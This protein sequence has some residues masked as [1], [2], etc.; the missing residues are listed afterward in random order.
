M[1]RRAAACAAAI[2]LALA[3]TLAP[4]RRGAAAG[5]GGELRRDV[6]AAAL[7]AREREGDARQR[8]RVE[9]SRARADGGQGP[10][11]T[12]LHAAWAS[13]RAAAAAAAAC[14][15][16]A[17]GWSRRPCDP[18]IDGGEDACHPLEKSASLSWGVYAW[19]D[20]GGG[21]GGGCD[22]FGTRGRYLD[23]AAARAVLRGRR[24]LFAGNS[25]LR[26]AMW[27]AV[28]SAQGAAHRRTVQ[29]AER[30][31][32][33]GARWMGSIE[34]DAEAAGG[35]AVIY[36]NPD[37]NHV[38][39]FAPI[40]LSDAPGVVP[41]D[42]REGERPEWRMPQSS[43]AD[44]LCNVSDAIP[45]RLHER[46]PGENLPSREELAECRR[47]CRVSQ[48][49][50]CPRGTR[51][52]ALADST[53]CKAGAGV[54]A[55]FLYAFTEDGALPSL[56]W[57][58]LE[59]PRGS[60]ERHVG[61]GADVVVV[62]MR[63]PEGALAMMEVRARSR[64]RANMLVRRTCE[65]ALAQTRALA[66]MLCFP[67]SSLPPPP[68]AHAHP[69]P[70]PPIPTNAPLACGQAIRM[71][72]DDAAQGLRAWPHACTRFLYFEVRRGMARA[73]TTPFPRPAVL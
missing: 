63:R 4:V 36:D 12:P 48:G 72:R 67:S 31:G 53:R 15:S 9:L 37:N 69:H 23:A 57:E 56:P 50:Y 71:L 1:A 17:G 46:V 70:S 38:A 24:L 2:V 51:P 5:G 7:A 35:H 25:V 19:G 20:E 47:Q 16:R 14:A 66:L 28:D 32:G 33:Q 42:P 64:S 3:C 10:S 27:A 60:E 55:C 34:A 61:A 54:Q 68:H 6:L 59:L 21:G 52:A 73:Q 41:A 40:D 44:S 13:E 18:A 29:W 22:P 8:A 43:Y 26:Q 49:L 45:G 11:S 58:L 39:Q 30:A 65:R 62:Q